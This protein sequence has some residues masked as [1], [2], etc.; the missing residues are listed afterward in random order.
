VQ[1]LQKAVKRAQS[2]REL[3]E[4]QEDV[5]KLALD[6]TDDAT[7]LC[8]LARA[9]CELRDRIRI[10]LGL[11]KPGSR[12]VSV[13]EE[14]KPPKRTR[15]QRSMSTIAGAAAALGITS[16]PAIDVDTVKPAE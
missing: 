16:G 14:P 15:G 3:R 1:T 9:Y 10:E 6:K 11:I 2:V 8:L 5:L 4:L 12:N 13:R 7:R